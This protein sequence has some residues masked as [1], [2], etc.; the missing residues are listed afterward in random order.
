MCCTDENGHYLV[1]VR[2][3]VLTAAGRHALHFNATSLS[4]ICRECY[5][6]K[7]RLP[8]L[9]ALHQATHVT[10]EELIERNTHTDTHG[11]S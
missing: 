7:E 5:P 1:V 2:R 9:Q 3:C 10:L 6:P 11:A 4:L 8:P